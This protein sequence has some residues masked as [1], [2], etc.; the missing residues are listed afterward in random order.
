VTSGATRKDHG[1][2]IVVSSGGVSSKNEEPIMAQ[3]MKPLKSDPELL[4]RLR[5]SV[6][7][8]KAMTPRQLAAMIRAQRKSWARQ[9]MD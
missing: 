9:D 6:A 4:R 1:S 3:M 7:Q 8:V 2:G 5:E